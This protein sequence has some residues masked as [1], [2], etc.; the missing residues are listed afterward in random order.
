MICKPGDED[1]LFNG[2][3]MAIE[4]HSLRKAISDHAIETAKE[5]SWDVSYNKFIKCIID[6]KNNT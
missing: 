1:E 5:L 4:D 3:R 2:M 6:I